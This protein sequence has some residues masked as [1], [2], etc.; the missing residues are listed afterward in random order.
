VDTKG[1]RG[2][3]YASGLDLLRQTP[4]FMEDTRRKRLD[5]GFNSAYRYVE[6]LFNGGNPYIESIDRS[7]AFLRQVLR[8]ESW[9][10]LRRSPQ[11]FAAEPDSLTS[12]RGLMASYFKRAWSRE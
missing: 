12:V 10:M 2:V 4:G 7:L 6:P 1:D 9:R 8:S 5:A 11:V 3:K